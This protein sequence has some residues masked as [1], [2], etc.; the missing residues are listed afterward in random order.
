[1]IFLNSASSAAVLA[2]YLPGVCTHTDTKGKQR[3]T[4]VRNI[5]K[6]FE[7]NT[8]F[9][10]HPVL[11]IFTPTLHITVESRRQ[12][13][14][15]PGSVPGDHRYNNIPIRQAN[16]SYLHLLPDTV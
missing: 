13:G 11:I 7:K 5:L 6:S 4:R 1:M 14:F 15:E 2:F 16:M 10:K 12:V 3:K 9:N 8:I